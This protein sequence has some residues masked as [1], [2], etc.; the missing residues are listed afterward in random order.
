MATFDE[1]INSIYEKKNDGKAF[2]LF[3]KHFLETSPDYADQ[4]EKV[5]M[6]DDW[7]IGPGPRAQVP[8]LMAGDTS[9]YLRIAFQ[10]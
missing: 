8:D 4:F 5:W 10:N 9:E 1:F 2:E 3:C 6:W 7:P